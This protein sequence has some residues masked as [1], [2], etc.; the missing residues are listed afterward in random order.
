MDLTALIN[1]ILYSLS[2]CDQLT[3][4]TKL[5]VGGY[6]FESLG[7]Q[8]SYLPRIPKLT[9]T[10]FQIA[11]ALKRNLI[12]LAEQTRCHKQSNI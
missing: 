10:K 11:A 8:S 3:R 12:I 1:N 7:H 6:S 4:S 2:L 5:Q 9:E